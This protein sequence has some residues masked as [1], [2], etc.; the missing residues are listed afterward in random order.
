MNEHILTQECKYDSMVGTEN[1]MSINLQRT[2]CFL[3]PNMFVLSKLAV[4]FF[5]MERLLYFLVLF[6]LARSHSYMVS[7]NSWH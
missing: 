1:G 4:T 5:T 2:I 3:L 7:R 6:S